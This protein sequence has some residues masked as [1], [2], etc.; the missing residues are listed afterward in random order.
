MPQAS[1]S[2]V[3]RDA[4][5]FFRSGDLQGC[6]Q[7][8]QDTVRKNPADAKLRIFLAQVLMVQGNW[9]RALN[10]LK[11]IGEMEASALPMVHAYGSAIHCERLRAEVFASRC[12][13]PDGKAKPLS[14]GRRPSSWRRRP[15]ERSTGSLSSG[16]RTQTRVSARCS[17]C[18]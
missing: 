12:W 9:E 7:S 5:E 11:V 1:D 15:A 14:C 13:A 4:E 3:R 6:L 16:S 18:C 10:Q 17:R 8:L 2:V